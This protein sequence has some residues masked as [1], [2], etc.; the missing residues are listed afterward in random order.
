VIERSPSSQPTAANPSPARLAES[1]PGEGRG[2][3]PA[4]LESSPSEGNGT[5]GSAIDRSRLPEPGP[6]KSFSLPRVEKSRLASGL[7]V[8][9]VNHATVPVISFVFLLR[10][11]S[12][13]DP[14]GQ[15]GLA[16]LTA[17][18]LD[19]G[20]GGRSAI[21][22]HEALAR[23]GAQLDTSIGPDAVVVAVTALS[24]FA[25]RALQLLADIVVR[26]SLT[27]ADV[28]RVRQLRTHR[29][30]QLGDLPAAVADRTMA[31]LLYGSHPYGHTPIGSR[32]SVGA[33]SP[34]DVRAFHAR[35]FRPADAVLVAVGDCKAEGIEKLVEA[36]FAGWSDRAGESAGTAA[37]RGAA[38]E[39]QTRLYGVPRPAA[40]QSELRIGQ[41]AVARD[42]PDYHAL[43]TANTILGGQFVSR[44]N[45]NL[46]EDKGLTYGA[47]TAFEFRR[48]PGP[49]TLHA[50]VQTEGTARAITESIGEISAIRGPRTASADEIALA[51]AALTKGYARHFETSEQIARAMTELALYDLPDDYFAQF[52]P[53]IQAVT[54]ADVTRVAAQYLDPSRL[55]VL[56][57]GDLDAISAD[58]SGLGLGDLMVLPGNPF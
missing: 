5:A 50:A 28:L 23:I 10:N 42:T 19:E 20:S 1:A 55:I 11:G 16:A 41:V 7:R 18:M 14:P 13:S 54:A 35:V 33:L 4:A 51:V 12:A 6:P 58:L 44:I 49:F 17:D 56:V 43:V 53:L 37:A 24:R 34:D 31:D 27:D 32:Q 15:E 30:A 45:L 9:T 48:M 26:P 57:V 52:V 25:D 22:I 8:W 38:V 40:P 2:Q 21:E 46:R 3:E 36:A 47:R 39:H 29:L